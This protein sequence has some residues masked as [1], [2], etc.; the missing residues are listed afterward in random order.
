[1]KILKEIMVDINSNADYFILFYVL[2]F[3]LFRA[4]LVADGGSQ[5]RDLIRA[6]ADSLCLRH[7]NAIS[8]PC[9]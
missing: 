8:E 1:M 6:I 7:S 2:S 9:L 4:T 3:C 5:V